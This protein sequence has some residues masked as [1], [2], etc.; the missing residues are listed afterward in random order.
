MA[1]PLESSGP[2]SQPRVEP[3]EVKKSDEPKLP[4]QVAGL[5]NGLLSLGALRPALAILTRIPWLV[6]AHPELADL[7]LMI[8]KHSI[9]PLYE[10]TFILKERNPSFTQPRPRFSATGTLAIPTRK[11]Q[12]TLIAPTPPST[13]SVD[14]VFFFPDWT[15]RVPLSTSFEDIVDVIEPLMNFIG[16]HISRDPL[17]VTKIT[18]LGRAQLVTT[19][20]RSLTCLTGCELHHRR[21]HWIRF[22]KRHQVNLTQ[23]IPS[24]SSGLNYFGYTSFLLFLSF[25]AMQCVRLTFGMSFDNTRR[26]QDG[27]YME[28]G[29]LVTPCTLNFVFAM[30]KLSVK[31][32]E[33]CGV[34]R[35]IQSRRYLELWRNLPIQILASSLRT[36]LT[37]LWLTIILPTLSYRHCDMSPIWGSMCWYMSS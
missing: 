33:S 18:R 35:I 28:S 11:H 13:A 30:C 36:R 3:V 6:D 24:G 12:L 1:A 26:L 4:N 15:Q 32:K 14:F 16:L 8:L 17:F 9:A 19:V 23:I 21:F 7:M 2:T 22:P 29:D 37:R 25:G 31:A 10:A 27:G 34:Y 5:V 20:S